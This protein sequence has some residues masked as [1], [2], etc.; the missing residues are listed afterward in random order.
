MI[1]LTRESF[2]ERR[3]PGWRSLLTQVFLYSCVAGFIS[4]LIKAQSSL[5]VLDPMTVLLLWPSLAFVLLSLL[6][7]VC[8]RL[9]HVSFAAGV[10]GVYGFRWVVFLVPVFEL[11]I[12]SLGFS[13]E[14][15]FVSGWQALTMLLTGGIL[16]VFIVPPA[17]M[18]VWVLSFGWLMWSW[19]RS[20]SE[21][22]V[23]RL[24]QDAVPG[25][26]ALPLLFLV[27][28][29]IGWT[30]LVGDIPVWSTMG[31][32]VERA[33]V[34]AQIDGYAW[35]AVY[36]RFPLAVG[37]EAHVSQTWLFAT[38]VWIVGLLILFIVLANAWQWSLRRFWVFAD[39]RRCLQAFGTVCLGMIGATMFGEGH[40]F[41]WTYGLA[42]LQL[43]LT[44][45]L[46]VFARA[47]EVDMLEATHGILTPER[48]LAAG[49]V[50]AADLEEWSWI[51]SV[52]ACFGAWLL[53]LS[54]F[55]AFALAFISHRQVLVARGRWELL[56]WSA[57]LS[58]GYLLAGWMMVAERASFGVL[59][60]AFAALMFLII[61]AWNWRKFG[62]TG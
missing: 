31:M 28:S 48:P 39:R 60:P 59:A 9:W 41:T 5:V 32:V 47:A 15:G 27:P 22:N 35:R 8:T 16:P 25:Y 34:A 53:G 2:S 21:R 29:L 52:A 26:L 11:L 57:L 20:T 50:R 36:E 3:F 42:F 30:I 54:V 10:G 44:T 40:A 13:N 55:L 38:L 14:L 7:F 56:G 43:A 49:W 17:V 61:F 19:W 62:R 12:R 37:G 4:Q 1:R 24:V 6:G 33:F 45:M 51:W 18:L 58:V 46:F 23:W